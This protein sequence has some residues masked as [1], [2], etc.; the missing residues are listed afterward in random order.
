MRIISRGY[1]RHSKDNIKEC[2]A[3]TKTFEPMCRQVCTDDEYKRLEKAFFEKEKNLI[4]KM[5]KLV[6]V[7]K[8][9][10]ELLWRMQVEAFTDL[11]D[12]YQDFDLSPAAESID[13]VIARFEQP[14]TKY[15][16]IIAGG[17]KV[18][19]VRVAH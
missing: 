10:I 1:W 2:F 4:G 5:V 3:V 14:W 11:L 7:Q 6:P 18:G 17:I 15:Y 13:K 19:A 8:K 12:K 16:F 9:D